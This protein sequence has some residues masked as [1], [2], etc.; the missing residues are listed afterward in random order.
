VILHA[1]PSHCTVC[2]CLYSWVLSDLVVLL[3]CK[4]NGCICCSCYFTSCQ[5]EPIQAFYTLDDMPVP[6][7]RPGIQSP[8]STASNPGLVYDPTTDMYVF[9]SASRS[10]VPQGQKGLQLQGAVPH[11]TSPISLP[12]NS[13][14]NAISAAPL[15]RALPSEVSGA[16]AISTPDVGSTGLRYRATPRAALD[17]D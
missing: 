10:T 9:P 12:T 15:P 6:T 2:S 13:S 17:A 3:F 16:G 5:Q 11:T 7:P 4:S 8:P 1:Q 14:E